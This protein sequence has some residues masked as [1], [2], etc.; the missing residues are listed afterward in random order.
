MILAKK[1]MFIIDD[2]CNI[3]VSFKQFMFVTY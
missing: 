2:I 1:K 3:N